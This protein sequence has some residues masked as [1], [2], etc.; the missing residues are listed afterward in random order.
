MA[1]YIPA[2]SCQTLF[3]NGSLDSLLPECSVARSIW[4]SVCELD[5]SQFDAKYR[6]DAEGRP[7]IDPRRLAGVWILAMVRGMS[8]SVVVAGVFGYLMEISNWRRGRAWG[9]V[10]AQ[11]EALWRQITHNLMLLIGYWK[12]LV[13]KGAP[14]G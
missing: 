4:G 12:P 3:V 8:S 13:L 2:D 1:R 7:A 14:S 11:A 6:N 10:G 5:F 9:K